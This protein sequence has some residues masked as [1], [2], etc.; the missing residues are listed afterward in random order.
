MSKCSVGKKKKIVEKK[1]NF[2][3]LVNDEDCSKLSWYAINVHKSSVKIISR[4]TSRYARNAAQ[5]PRKYD[6]QHGHM[7]EKVETEQDL[8]NG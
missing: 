3:V 1:H 2:N 6:L 5:I 7:S 8:W 4:I